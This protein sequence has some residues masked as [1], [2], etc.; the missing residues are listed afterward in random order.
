MRLITPTRECMYCLRFLLGC[1]PNFLV[2]TG[3]FRAIVFRHASNGENFVACPI[4]TWNGRTLRL[5]ARQSRAYHSAAACE[6]APTAC[7]VVI[8]FA[9]C[10]N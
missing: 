4:R 8:C 5:M 10:A 9:A 3:G 2:H 7:A 6:T 1:V